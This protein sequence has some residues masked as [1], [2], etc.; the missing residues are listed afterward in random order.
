MVPTDLLNTSPSLCLSLLCNSS[1]STLL[2]F[3]LLFSLLPSFLPPMYLFFHLMPVLWEQLGSGSLIPVNLVMALVLVIPSLHLYHFLPT[4]HTFYPE[5]EAQ[6][7]NVI[8]H[9]ITE[10]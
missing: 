2:Y 9:H 10:D 7:D 8:S 3:L 4:Q 5:D 6:N 1:H